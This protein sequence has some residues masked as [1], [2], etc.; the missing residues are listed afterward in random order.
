MGIKGYN[1]SKT[2]KENKESAVR[3]RE[4]MSRRRRVLKRY[5]KELYKFCH[6]PKCK[7]PYR[8]CPE[9]HP[10]CRKHLNHVTASAWSLAIDLRK[11]ISGNSLPVN[12]I[13][14]LTF[15]NIKT[16][17]FM[18]SND[19][20]FDD[21]FDRLEIVENEILDLEDNLYHCLR[22]CE[23]HDAE[24]IEKELA[25]LD[26]KKEDLD[27]WC[28]NLEYLGELLEDISENLGLLGDMESN[29]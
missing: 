11:A 5:V 15:L 13:Y 26:E 22:L 4:I 23:D 7:Q 3:Q 20:H 24:E 14:S 27:Y 25:T 2:Y 1:N 12:E 8:S 16:E 21:I 10:I 29:D 6:D 19:I 17:F 9:K 18:G 28:D